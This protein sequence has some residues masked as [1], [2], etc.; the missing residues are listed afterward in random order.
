MEIPPAMSLHPQYFA[1]AAEAEAA[2]LYI[3]ETCSNKLR[4]EMSKA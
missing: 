3:L 4:H 1:S 2:L